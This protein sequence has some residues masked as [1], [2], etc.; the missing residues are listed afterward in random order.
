MSVAKKLMESILNGS[1]VRNTISN[2]FLTEEEQVYESI[3]GM[4]AEEKDLLM[5]AFPEWIKGQESQWEYKLIEFSSDVFAI[6]I[7]KNPIAETQ[8]PIY[9]EKEGDVINVEA[10]FEPSDVY[11]SASGDFSKLGLKSALRDLDAQ[12]KAEVDEYE[13]WLEDPTNV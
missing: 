12:W 3:A 7:S 8:A 5:E 11:V 4:S 9:L 13:E 6:K 2:S 1:D 10:Y